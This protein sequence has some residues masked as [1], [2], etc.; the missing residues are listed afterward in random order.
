MK[1]KNS[2]GKELSTHDY[3]LWGMVF[4]AG[5][6]LVLFRITHEG[7]WYDESYTIAAVQNSFSDMF[8]M[9]GRDSHPP[10]YFLMLKSFI[11]LFGE[12]IFVFRLFSALAIILMGVMGFTHIRRLVSNRAGL[13]YSILVFIT[14]VSIFQAQETRMY[15]WCGA[16]VMVALV[17][18]FDAIKNESL[19]N[20]IIGSVCAYAA[21]MIHYYGLIAV[22]I[23]YGLLFLRAL[24]QQR[25]HIVRILVTC[26][27]LLVC[28]TP[29][30]FMLAYQTSRISKG[31]WIKPMPFTQTLTLF[32][33]FYGFKFGMPFT[34]FMLLGSTVALG[35]IVVGI[36]SFILKKRVEDQFALISITMFFLTIIA[37]FV[38]SLLFR[39]ILTGRYLTAVLGP[40][41]FAV[42]YGINSMKNRYVISIALLIYATVTLPVLYGIYSYNFNGPMD[43]VHYQIKDEVK[44]DDIFI[45]GSE[46]TFGT[47]YH[48]FPNNHHYLY[49]SSDQHAYSNYEVFSKHGDYGD[50]Y[51]EY[52]DKAR[53]RVWL[54]NRTGDPMRLPPVELKSHP[55]MKSEGKVSSFRMPKSWFEVELSSF[56]YVSEKD[57]SDEVEFG[58]LKITITGVKGGG[59]IYWGFYNSDPIGRDNTISRGMG[60]VEDGTVTLNFTGLEYA[61]YAI[62]C[63][64]DSDGNINWDE[65]KEGVAIFGSATS[66]SGFSM[67]F[68][69]NGFDFDEDHQEFQIE[70]VYP[71]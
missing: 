24:I 36:V 60:S 55:H 2:D 5:L 31:F 65:K 33:Y 11:T 3:F 41:L 1:F 6:F 38:L 67:T 43:K 58:D 27:T 71:K 42:A 70:M 56:Q 21:A 17:F 69:E 30:F 25:E 23:L 13:I 62:F 64:E 40:F 39:P 32:S 57:A 22:T 51:E 7:V 53:G 26:V 16:M 19:K 46:H 15:S 48:Y 47:F 66:G 28:Y 44:S 59:K 54:V 50:N 29:V 8:G 68:A 37:G 52:L 18:L 34:V 61:R 14:P 49:I 35:S 63:W 10:L 45:H 12:S 4:L 20:W 9:I